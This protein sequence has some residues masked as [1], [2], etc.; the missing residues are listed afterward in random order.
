MLTSPAFLLAVALLVLN[1]WVLKAR[2]G[3]WWTG[4]LSDVA[5]LFAF[6]VFWAVLLP[7]HRGHVFALTAAGFAI[8]KSPLSQPLL[9]AWNALGML[10]LGRVIDYGD[11]LALLVLLPAWWFVHRLS[12]RSALHGPR[13]ARRAGAI[14][15][16]VT[17][18]LAFSATTVRPPQ[19]PLPAADGYLVR[20]SRETVRAGLDS[21]AG[22]VYDRTSPGRGSS[23]ELQPDTVAILLR[24]PPE[25]IVSLVIEL[26]AVT[27]DETRIELL[28]V[29]AAGPRPTPEGVHRAFH[30]Q[31][32]EPLRAW[33]ARRTPSGG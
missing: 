24:H 1:D 2:Y 23:D 27:P 28:T 8:W 30:E 13:R 16:A 4:K 15:A 31:I 22:Q 21:V 12:E 33:L 20:G 29:S 26:R 18:I 17:A 7:R 32:L 19:H 5:G 14:F 3:N 25:R 6:A 9:D 11:W 10:P